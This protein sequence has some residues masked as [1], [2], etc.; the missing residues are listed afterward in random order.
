MALT[1]A[2][3]QQIKD[4]LAKGME[5]PPSDDDVRVLFNKEDKIM[6]L[7]RKLG[8]RVGDVKLLWSMLVDYKNGT[9]TNVPWK[10]M[11]AVVFFFTYLLLPFDVIP[12]F[13]PFVG[14]TDD[15]GVLGLVL[16]GFTADIDAYKEWLASQTI[17]EIP[18]DDDEAKEE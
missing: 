7:F 10:L 6:A 4:K 5:K 11:A 18:H 16:A 9:Y 1:K 3:Q 17:K 15:L 12:D 13:I 2:Q 8:E 14:F